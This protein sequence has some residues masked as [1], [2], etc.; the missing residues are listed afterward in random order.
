M[1]II[2]S[3][4]AAINA[5][6]PLA[7]GANWCPSNRWCAP[8][9]PKPIEKTHQ[10]KAG[11]PLLAASKVVMVIHTHTLLGAISWMPGLKSACFVW[12]KSILIIDDIICFR[13]LQEASLPSLLSAPQETERSTR[14]CRLKRCCSSHPLQTLGR[15]TVRHIQEHR[16]K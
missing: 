5:V 10:G 12:K 14:T 9:Q 16:I 6:T 11:R 2:S 4:K 8:G 7:G 1:A 13:L 15:H 3:S